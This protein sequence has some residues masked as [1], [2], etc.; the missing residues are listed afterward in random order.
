MEVGISGVGFLPNSLYS[1]PDRKKKL[2][3]VKNPFEIVYD[4]L[5]FQQS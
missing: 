4:F 5:I 2:L 1:E 3:C